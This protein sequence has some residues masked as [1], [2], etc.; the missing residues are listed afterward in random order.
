MSRP[1][2]GAGSYDTTLV[3]GLNKIDIG[4]RLASTPPS[5]TTSRKNS[6]SDAIVSKKPPK[7]CHECG[8]VIIGT[9]VRAMDRIYHVEC[10][11]CYDCGNQCSNKF[12]AA[13]VEIN[14]QTVQVPL[15]EYDYFKRID[16]ICSTCDK[17]IRGSYITAVGQKF[18]PEHF[19]C[20]VCH[21]VFDSEDY[22]EH[23]NKIYCHYHYSILYAAQCEACKSAI[24]KQ[25]VDLY[26]G[27]RDQQWHPECFMVHKFWGVDVT[28]ECIGLNH[29]GL[30]SLAD[31]ESKS[32]L[33]PDQLFDVEKKLERMTMSIWVTLSEFEEGC[34]SCISDML[35]CASTGN[36]LGGL[37]VTGQLVLKVEYLF[38]GIDILHDCAEASRIHIDYSTN[39]KLSPL[40]KEPRSMSSKIMSYL[41]FLRDTDRSKLLSS[42]HTQQLLSLIST[43]A[44]YIK[45]ISRNTLLHA[46]EYN[47]VN[48]STIA[49]DRYLRE[50][51]SHD[52]IPQDVFS[53]LGVPP[54]AKDLCFRCQKSIE[55]DC[56]RFGDH[57][58][59]L[60]CFDCS[61]CSKHLGSQT[62]LSEVTFNVHTEKILCASC[63]AEDVDAQPGFR[64]VSRYMQL[65]YLLKIALIR[66]RH[67][68]LK[69]GIITKTPSQTLV[70][71]DSYD[72]HVSDIKRM[73]SKRQNQRIGVASAEA[74]KSI[75]VEAPEASS[76][77]MEEVDPESM[78]MYSSSSSASK[79]LRKEKSLGRKGSKRL[80][81]EDV[82]M[83]SKPHATN[84][85][86]TS[87]L[88][89]NEKGLTLDDIPR[90]VSSEQAREHRPNAFKFQKR[91]YTPANSTIPAPKEVKTKGTDSIQVPAPLNNKTS[92]GAP[93][94]PV[95]Q[96][97]ASP[98]SNG[99]PRPV[100]RAN[101]STR[102]AAVRYSEFSKKDNE[103]LQHI[104]AFSLHRMMGNTLSLEDCLSFIS[105]K[106]NASFWE[107]MFGN[108][109][110][111]KKSHGK[112]FGSPL[113][114]L[115]E[116]YGVESDLGLGPKKLRIPMF[117]DE[118]INVMHT[119]DL[120]V[121]GV[122]RI[123]GNI[124][125]LRQLTEEI[126]NNPQ[127][128]PDL[129]KE[130]PIQLA[131]LLKRFTREMP[132][133]LLTF[134]LYDLFILSHKFA[135]DVAK[136]DQILKLA[137]C[138]LPKVH[139]DLAEVLFSF[140]NWVAS[141]CLIDEENG[142]KMDIHNLA[143]VLTPNILY[144]RPKA[145]LKDIPASSSD[146][147]PQGENHFLAIEV[148]NTLIE[149]QDEFSIVPKEI[150]HV[151]EQAGFK[152]CPADMKTKD[153]LARCNSVY[154]EHPN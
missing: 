62:N 108:S 9:L 116:K 32:S 45:L 111:N 44:H 25:Y 95:P 125:R 58:W 88:L 139:R 119:M 77:G 64:R 40:S 19:F 103:F 29:G 34:A 102:P 27:G 99:K 104:A 85:D 14:N 127:Q 94:S 53:V 110:S 2:N 5:S 35:H 20:E 61:N 134:K 90:I 153:I 86:V 26:R 3:A 106:K 43:L 113:E 76:A 128:V 129:S 17:A 60:D 148:I 149:A 143:T 122:F 4:P 87:N 109:G 50:L 57:R 123:N 39:H 124:K 112:V 63:S 151:Y 78:R 54:N 46:L 81:I 66:S 15:C 117:V 100:D 72:Q 30:K 69:R 126:D 118:I 41:T 144:S 12:F 150:L 8:K 154:N 70:S 114:D 121:E 80:R 55:E 47:K 91:A 132:D 79:F 24:L 136:R 133:P 71:S 68:M 73:R 51:S 52:S 130:T 31:P 89:K 59:H 142:S 49:T 75:I 140:F 152:N 145:D 96:Y 56:Y 18:H 28:V 7:I 33:S 135:D 67:A 42:S 6:S 11:R 36:Q 13:D 97:R 74:R 83:N 141:F 92:S 38:R 10:F 48:H 98:N 131:A 82:P 137:Y 138:M 65:I 37:L 22:Y 146:L 23:Q 16:L 101:T 1:V 84:L 147:V 105:V 120:S 115:V 93:S 107:K 21:K